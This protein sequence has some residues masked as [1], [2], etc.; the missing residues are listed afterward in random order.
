MLL[1]TNQPRS[2]PSNL[3]PTIQ[4]TKLNLALQLNLN[5]DPLIWGISLNAQPDISIHLSL[6]L[7]PLLLTIRLPTNR[8]DLVQQLSVRDS[9]C[10]VF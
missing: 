3:N 2:E 5:F 6:S 8:C 7:S 4:P 9:I 1:W 10:G